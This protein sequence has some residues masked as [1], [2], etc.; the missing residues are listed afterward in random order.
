MIKK[1]DGFVQCDSK[2]LDILKIPINEMIK[3]SEYKGKYERDLRTF[4]WDNE[5]GD[6]HFDVKEFKASQMLTSNGQFMQFIKDGGYHK[7][8]L[9]TEE[10]QRW[11]ASIKP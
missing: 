11:I 5:F 8:E 6:K 9:W 1:V 3:V 10:G 4:G 2:Q 7:P